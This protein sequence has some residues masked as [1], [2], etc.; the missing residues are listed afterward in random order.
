M[1]GFNSL[2]NVS[3]L[4]IAFVA[5]SGDL[6]DGSLEDH[7]RFLFVLVHFEEIGIAHD[8]YLIIRIFVVGKRVE[9]LCLFVVEGLILLLSHLEE[10]LKGEFLKGFD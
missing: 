3:K 1:Y 2:V 10:G 5:T 6:L 4:H 8:Q 9:V 7:L